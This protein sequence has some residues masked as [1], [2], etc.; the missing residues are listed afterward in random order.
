MDSSRVRTLDMR[1]AP[2]QAQETVGRKCESSCSLKPNSHQEKADINVRHSRSSKP[3]MAHAYGDPHA[4]TW[5]IGT[6]G[7][8]VSIAEYPITSRVFEAKLCNKV[9]RCE[10]STPL[11]LPVVPEV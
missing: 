6:T 2:Q 10:Y 11:G 4:L 1:N 5:N 9:E 3:D 7:I 8:T